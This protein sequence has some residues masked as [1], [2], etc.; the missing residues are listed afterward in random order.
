[1]GVWGDFRWEFG[2]FWMGVWGDF[3]WEFWGFWMGVWR[4]EILDFL[5]EFLSEII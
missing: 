5:P 2:G 3:E 1:M 4:G